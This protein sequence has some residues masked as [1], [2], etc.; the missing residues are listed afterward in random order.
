MNNYTLE[1]SEIEIACGVTLEQVQVLLPKVLMRNGAVYIPANTGAALAGATAR[2]ALAG[3]VD[4]Q[5]VNVLGMP[6]YRLEGN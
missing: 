5:G 2:C 6:F 3:P 1:L 4:F